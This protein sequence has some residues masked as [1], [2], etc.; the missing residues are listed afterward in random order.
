MV[1]RV[2]MVL[3]VMLGGAVWAGAQAGA[4]A[5]KGSSSP[6]VVAAEAQ[7]MAACPDYSPERG[8]GGIAAV[9]V[10]ALGVLAKH[11]FTL[12]PERRITGEMAVVWYPKIGVFAW[13]PA[14]A[15]A[16]HAL[17]EIVDRITRLDDFP[18]EVTVWDASDEELAASGAPEFH[19]KETYHPDS[20]AGQP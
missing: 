2:S 3:S 7:A 12:C 11:K 17:A 16:V 8:N 4:G 5:D 14:D 1:M 13:N 19:L 9:P 18:A 10:A 20:T 6:E 15:G